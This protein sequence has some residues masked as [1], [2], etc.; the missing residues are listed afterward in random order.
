MQITN[1]STNTTQQTSDRTFTL[2]EGEVYKAIIKERLPNNE[3]ILQIRGR[4]IHTRFESNLPSTERVTIQVSENK[5]GMPVVRFIGEERSGATAQQADQKDINRILLNLGASQSPTRALRQAAQTLL[6]KGV[7]LTRE[8]VQELQRY[9]NSNQGTIEQR[10]QTIQAMANKRLEI[11]TSQVRAVHEVLHGRP[12]NQVVSNIV[13][14][15]NVKTRIG[16]DSD[17][18]DQNT[19]RIV[20]EAIRKFEHQQGNEVRRTVYNPRIEVSNNRRQTENVRFIDQRQAPSQLSDQIR[21]VREQIQREPNVQ[22]VIDQVRQQVVNNPLIDRDVV[23]S[24]ERASREAGQLLQVSQD[25]MVQSLQTV[26]RQLSNQSKSEENSRARMAIHEVKNQLLR[27]QSIQ[28]GVEQLRTSFLNQT[29]DRNTQQQI[30]KIIIQSQQ[31]ENVSKERLSQAL[32]SIERATVNVNTS[33]ASQLNP[34]QNNIA[35][36]EQASSHRLSEA[37]RQM[38]E[39]I[40]KEAN[41][42]RAVEQVKL[43]INQNSNSD[44]QIIDKLIKATDE[45]TL[46]LNQ[47][48]E[49]AARQQLMQALTQLE[50]QA[51]AKEGIQLSDASKQP[52]DSNQ[53]INNEQFQTSVQLNSKDIAVTTITEKLAKAAADFKNL[54]REITRNLDVTN[55]LINQFKSQAQHQAKPL[56]ETTIKKLDHAIL[57]SEMM[58]LTD[59][60]TEKRLMQASSRLA[61]AKKLLARGQFQEANRIVQEVKGIVERLQFKPS[62]TKVMH[63]I[64]NER[65]ILDART[66]QQQ[67]VSQLNEMVKPSYGQE[68]SARQAFEMVRGVGLNRESEIGMLLANSREHTEQD[69]NHRNLK[70]ALMMLMRGEEE[71]S[72][73]SQQANQALNNLTGQQLLSKSDQ[74]NLQSMFF[75]LPFLLEEQVENLQVFVN[76]RNEGEQVD[77]ENCSLYFLIE[78]KKLGEIGIMVSVVDRNLSVTLKNNQS[79]FQTKMEPLVDKCVDN[80]KDIGY[81]VNGIKFSKLSTSE[82]QGIELEEKEIQSLAQQPTFTEK[83]FDFKI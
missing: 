4:D 59:M 33:A 34:T 44:K 36:Q 35:L 7:P 43:Q 5:Q 31:I 38:Q 62:E 83:G 57:K 82:D 74:G 20:K 30:E 55:R 2:R 46:L 13:Q 10:H 41:F 54:Q 50:Q 68:A 67:G 48:R 56:L 25:R 1:Q 40:Q 79:M 32:I 78:T 72:R 70:S 23:L 52:V 37:L 75:N 77:W 6:D 73:L 15:V 60:K 53:Y 66:P 76:S 11:T 81:N 45:S 69:A 71:G 28:R 51:L 26:E 49:M 8:A 65:Q 80:I 19:E 17:R 18:I 16:P 58:L 29:F 63:F 12:L 22:R 42:E 24:V 39:Y 27:D 47:G 3:A 61:E 21:Q 14:E 64:S 9:M